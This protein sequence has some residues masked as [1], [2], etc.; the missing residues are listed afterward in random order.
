MTEAWDPIFQE[1]MQ[2][3]LIGIAIFCAIC[4][5]SPTVN[6]P[7]AASSVVPAYLHLSLPQKLVASYIMGVCSILILR[8]FWH[9]S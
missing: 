4:L 9:L 8:P 2:F 1:N 6:D 3:G 5:L 7:S